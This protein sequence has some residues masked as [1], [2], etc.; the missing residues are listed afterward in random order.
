MRLFLLAVMS[1]AVVLTFTSCTSQEERIRQMA[2]GFRELN[3]P[4]Q[5]NNDELAL[6]NDELSNDMA[7]HEG[8]R[9]DMARIAVDT[10]MIEQD[11]A[12]IEIMNRFAD[13]WSYSIDHDTMKV[14]VGDTGNK[15]L[16]RKFSEIERR[17]DAANDEC[18]KHADSAPYDHTVPKTVKEA[19]ARCASFREIYLAVIPGATSEPHTFASVPGKTGGC[20]GELEEVSYIATVESS[21]HKIARQNKDKAQQRCDEALSA[22]KQEAAKCQK[23]AAST[24]E[25]D[26]GQTERFAC[27]EEEKRLSAVGDVRYAE[28]NAAARHLNAITEREKK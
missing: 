12:A 20:V 25:T 18:H 19:E 6:K 26:A 13:I 23:V 10:Y 15:D 4:I 24:D 3:L 1:G 5:L 17:F 21:N 22:M 7:Y 28:L 14:T 16:Q 8:R 2:F 11:R 27:V 9:K